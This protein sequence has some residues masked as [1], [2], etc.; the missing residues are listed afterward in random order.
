MKSITKRSLIAS[1]SAVCVLS[2]AAGAGILVSNSKTAAAEDNDVPS[3]V[4]YYDNLRN[5][6][7][8]EYPLA[9]K[10]YEAIDMLNRTG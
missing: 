7:G 3:S 9:K 5:K 8:E 2:V 10:S 1:L 4:Y 6:N